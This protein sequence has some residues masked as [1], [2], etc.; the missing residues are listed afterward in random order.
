MANGHRAHP[1]TVPIQRLSLGPGPVARCEPDLHRVPHYT[2]TCFSTSLL[3]N[4][5]NYKRD[6]TW[7]IQPSREQRTQ[8][9]LPSCSVFLK[10]HQ[11]PLQTPL[12]QHCLCL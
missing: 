7:C 3:G 6:L 10:S 12:D 1:W 5:R 9:G 4:D 2:C 11:D 8:G